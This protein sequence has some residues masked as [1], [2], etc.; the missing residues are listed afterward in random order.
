VLSISNYEIMK[1]KWEQLGYFRY[2]VLNNQKLPRKIKKNIIG[3]RLNKNKRLSKF[4]NQDFSFCPECG[5][6]R[7][8]HVDLGAEYPEVWNETRC[9]KCGYVIGG[10]DNSSYEFS[11][12]GMIYNDFKRC[13]NSS[14]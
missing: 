14:Y 2:M 5:C 12:Y 9:I 8:R 4:R 11:L 7:F 13:I 10:Q 6:Q 3:Q 1:I